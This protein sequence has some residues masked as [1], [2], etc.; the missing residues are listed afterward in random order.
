MKH[1]FALKDQKQ[2][3]ELFFNRAV[4]AFIVIGI[5]FSMIIIRLGYLQLVDHSRYITLAEN[6]RVKIVPVAPNR[7]LIYDR[8]G[9]LLAENLPAY[10]LEIIPEQVDDIELII[11]E[12][13]YIVAITKEDKEE[14]YTTLKKKRRFQGIPIRLQLTDEELANFSERR[15]E[16][17]GVEVNA[18]LVRHYIYPALTAH[19][20]GYVGR[21]NEQEMEVIDKSNYSASLHMGK[22]GVEKSYEKELHGTVGYQQV[23]VNAGGRVVRVLEYNPPEAGTDLY[24]GIDINLQRV[25]QVAL[26]EKKG[27][28]VA[29]DPNTGEI[30]A[31]VS[32]PT[33]DANLFIQGIDQESYTALNTS[34][35]RPLFNRALIGQYP[36]GSTVKPI[37]GLYALENDF[38]T[39]RHSIYDPGHFVLGG[40]QRFRDWRAHGEVD[41]HKAITVSCNTYFY[42]LAHK[43]GINHLAN[44]STQF[45]YGQTTGIDLPGEAK[46]IVPSPEWKE[47]AHGQPW[48][49]GETIS[50]GIGQGYTLVTPIQ[51][52]NASAT[53]ANK[54]QRMQPRIV[55]ATA[56]LGEEPVLI[57]PIIIDEIPIKN[58]KNWDY[59][60]KAMQGVAHGSGGTAAGIGYNS[61]YRIAGKTGTAQVFNLAGGSYNESKLAKHLRDHKLFIAFA[62][63]DDPK[64]AVAVLVENDIGQTAIARTVMDYYLIGNGYVDFE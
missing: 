23:E 19:S 42:Q 41:L 45:G 63:A 55:R 12:L 46:G 14:F 35:D 17:P 39:P 24:L 9:V 13:S 44:A 54:G 11:E 5:I 47:K 64:I 59:M 6:N 15:H 8:N 43:M 38:T 31:F 36:P 28:V 26:G 30:L 2:E 33:F 50:A 49:P 40:R 32:N 56:P 58:E 29:I 22:V 48:Y 10:S 60:N 4:T 34:P 62:P 51:L 57:D 1:E 52:A 16:F 3:K 20:I 25:A 18:G 53:M 37:F 61:P 21:I 7:G 27:A